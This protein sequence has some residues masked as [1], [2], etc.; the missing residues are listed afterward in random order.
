MWT[1]N[2][3]TPTWTNMISVLV[4]GVY[5]RVMDTVELWIV[6]RQ[7]LCA[8]WS[9]RG[10]KRSKYLMKSCMHLYWGVL[11]HPIPR[12][13]WFTSSLSSE[14]SWKKSAESWT[15][16]FLWKHRTVGVLKAGNAQRT[17]IAWNRL[18]VIRFMQT[19]S[20]SSTHRESYFGPV[21]IT[22]S[23]NHNGLL[24]WWQS[25]RRKKNALTLYIHSIVKEWK[26]SEEKVCLSTG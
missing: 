10:E 16:L 5:S 1:C 3:Y 13:S 17:P 18:H 26:F 23:D 6:K 15:L 4:C 8:K 2:F 25:R 24:I 21:S 19:V 20:C 11:Y 22:P 14:I 12:Y 9:V 7:L